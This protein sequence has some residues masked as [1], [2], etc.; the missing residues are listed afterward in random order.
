M[1]DAEKREKV[2]RSL[3]TAV[4]NF[5]RYSGDEY[6]REY[7]YARVEVETLEDAL[8]LL[9]AQ[10]PIEARLNLCESCA[11]EYAECEADKTDLVYGSGVGNDNIIGCPWY[12]NRWKAQ[13][14]RV[15]TLEEMEQAGK[16][17][18]AVYVETADGV[19]FWTLAFPGEEPPKDKPFN[20]PGGV[21]FNAQD[22][23]G[24][25]YDGDFYCMTMP[26][27]GPH[28][29]AWRAWTSRPTDEQREATPWNG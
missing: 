13:E 10:E 21:R 27:G 8:A 17:G 5:E 16:N 7:D 19:H 2:I 12:A 29:L 15:M 4:K 14:P 11:K 28:H 9:K 1:T 3:E 25:I 26:D 20:Y 6:G 22:V 18:D 24:D 23:D